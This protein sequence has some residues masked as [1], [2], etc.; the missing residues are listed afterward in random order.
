MKKLFCIILALALALST[1]AFAMTEEEAAAAAAAVVET[2][3]DKSLI[4]SPFIGVIEKVTPS[5]IGVN[6][7]QKVSY[8]NSGYSAFGFP[9]DYFFGYPDSGMNG[10]TEQEETERLAGTGSGTVVFDHIVLTNYHV[11][12][13]ASRLTVSILREDNEYDATL[14]CWDEGLDVAVL[15]VPD[16]DLPAIPLGDSDQM[17]VGEWVLCVGNPLGE[18]LRGTVTKGIVSA[19]DRAISSTTTTDKYGLKTDVVNSM[20]QIDAAIN[21]GN[22][23][24]GMFNTLGQLMGIPSL[25]YS[26]YSTS[27][28]TIEGIG[29]CIPINSAKPLIREAIEKVLTGKVEGAGK[30]EEGGEET[31]KAEKPMIGITG[32]AISASN[33]YLVSIGMLPAGVMID[34]VVEGGPS[35]KSGMQRYDVIVDVNDHII[36]SVTDIHDILEECAYGDTLQLKLYR[37]ENLAEA[38]D[39]NDRSLLGKGKYID[40]EV[41]L[42]PFDMP[43]EE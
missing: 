28:A 13:N 3:T 5:V 20:I 12:E 22:S 43:E 15:Y 18:E 32:A 27:G 1:C 8:N 40:F 39:K 34:S 7:Y 16:L 33:Y 4:E 38:I 2:T 37:L 31:E 6:N 14:V 25:K 10:G 36:T 19:I 35:D 9:F 11:T 23:G 17:Q 26:G 21:N 29:M 41:E 42:F 30:T 24:G